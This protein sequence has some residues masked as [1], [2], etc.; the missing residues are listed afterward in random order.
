MVF[1]LD[2]FYALWTFLKRRKEVPTTDRGKSG[3][4]SPF[5]RLRRLRRRR[6]KRARK[7]VARARR[8]GLRTE[9]EGRNKMDGRTDGRTTRKTRL[10][11]NQSFPQGSVLAAVSETHRSVIVLPK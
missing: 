4:S 2:V 7:Y 3:L 8:G 1:K 10:L 6:R 9:E 11:H 5:C